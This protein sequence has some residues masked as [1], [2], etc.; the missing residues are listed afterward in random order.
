M[1]ASSPRLPRQDDQ[2][3]AQ[4]RA[5]PSKRF[6]SISHQGVAASYLRVCDRHVPIPI[7]ARSL[8][9]LKLQISTGI[10]KPSVMVSPGASTNATSFLPSSADL[11][12]AFPRLLSKVS[13]LGDMMRA[14]GSVIAEPTAN[15]TNNT[16]TSTVSFI[17]EPHST[18][19]AA[20][21]ASSESDMTVWQALRNVATW[22]SYITSKWAIATFAIVSCTRV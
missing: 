7:V 17:Q 18:A 10:R 14:G 3:A 4:P 22:F 5:D 12:M 19:A 21:A 2:L 11:L 13:S 6:L 20:V 15:L 1:L 8:H 16:I 9:F